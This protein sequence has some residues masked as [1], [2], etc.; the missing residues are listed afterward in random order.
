M[1]TEA[2]MIVEIV[3]MRIRAFEALL[4]PALQK[5]VKPSSFDVGVTY[6]GHR[7]IP[8]FKDLKNFDY[9][10]IALLKLLVQKIDRHASFSVGAI[11][12]DHRNIQVFKVSKIF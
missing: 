1:T 3:S 11:L 10:A 6:N 5:I 4:K 9:R 2:F 7:R 12:N 8:D